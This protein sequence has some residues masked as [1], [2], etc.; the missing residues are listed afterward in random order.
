[1]YV[2][3]TLHWYG[4]AHPL[5]VQHEFGWVWL[6]LYHTKSQDYFIPLEVNLLPYQNSI[7]WTKSSVL[8][9]VTTMWLTYESDIQPTNNKW[10]HIYDPY[11]PV[12]CGKFFVTHFAQLQHFPQF[13]KVSQF[14]K[15]E[16]AK[17]FKPDISPHH[18]VIVTVSDRIDT[19]NF[20]R[21]TNTKFCF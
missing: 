1:M 11:L 14:N 19:L 3:I 6:W 18:H 5:S 15:H 9:F 16:I 2:Q 21:E 12:F 10:L 8:N 13:H 7:Y 20:W 17:K 4:F